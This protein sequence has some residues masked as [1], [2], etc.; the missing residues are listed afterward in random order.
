MELKLLVV[1]MYGSASEWQVAADVALL[2]QAVSEKYLP[3]D[4]AEAARMCRL[5]C[6]FVSRNSCARV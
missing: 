5:A 1:C 2:V 6:I 4:G 3:V